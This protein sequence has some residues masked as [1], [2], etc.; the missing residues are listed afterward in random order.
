MVIRIGAAI[1]QPNHDVAA[2]GAVPFPISASVAHLKVNGT[3]M[4]ASLANSSSTIA[5]MTRSLRSRRS[6]GQI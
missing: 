6:V 4:V 2:T 3:A 1:T 5:T